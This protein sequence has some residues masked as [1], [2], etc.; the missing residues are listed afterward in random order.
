[1]T[2]IV[3]SGYYGFSNT[4]DEAVL[5]AIVSGLK[6][7]AGDDIE[8]TVLSASPKETASLHKVGALPRTSISDVAGAL[9][10]CDLL[11]SGGGSLIQDATS[12]RSLAYYLWIIALAKLYKRKVMILGQG[13]GPL[14]RSI[15]RR[16]AR[17]VLNRVDLITVRD[18]QSAEL[19]GELGVR[20]PPVHVTADPTFLLAPASPEESLRLLSS[21]GIGAEE[22]V[23]AISLRRWPESPET[24]DTTVKALATLAK[25]LPAKL[26][27][28]AMHTPEDD[29]LARRVHETVGS[30][31]I[32]VQ[33][34]PW[35]AGELLG[36]LGRCRF[37]VAM[38]LHALIFAAS[39]GTPSL[40]IK[41]DPKVGNFLTATGQEGIT[42]EETASGLL[43]ERAMGAWNARDMLASRLSESVPTMREAAADN[44]RLALSFFVPI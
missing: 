22:D 11:I 5:S 34:G 20:K 41:Y 43:A 29:L 9:R 2:H 8:I 6:S 37:V 27:L 24:E 35:T 32:A 23:V 21:A 12:F 33:P 19:L 30:P 18:A 31:Q 10:N 26:L 40:G 42:L 4:G 1:M 16:L 14:R 7:Q 38:R 39:V 17:R 15:S 25:E 13:I 44:I 3:I 36:V 28:V